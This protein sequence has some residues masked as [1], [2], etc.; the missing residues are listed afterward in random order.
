MQVTLDPASPA[1]LADAGAE[2]EGT[3]SCYD[4]GWNSDSAIQYF[5]AAEC[6]DHLRPHL[7]AATLEHLDQG[8]GRLLAEN[9]QVDEFGHAEAS[10]G[11]SWISASPETTRAILGHIEAVDLEHLIAILRRH[12][13]ASDD[14]ET[15]LRVMF[16]QHREVVRAAAARG[17]GL[18]GHCG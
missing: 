9:G 2:D 10:E 13:A 8:L 12:P 15:S 18:V 7:D 16:T 11:H 17:L 1:L 5:E 3:P 14:A 4:L 6:L